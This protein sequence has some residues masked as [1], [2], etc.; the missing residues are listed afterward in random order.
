MEIKLLRNEEQY[1]ISFDNKIT[2]D[3]GARGVRDFLRNYSNPEY[4]KELKE[5]ASLC[6]DSNDIYEV[7]AY[8]GEK[9]QLC[10]YTPE[11]MQLVFSAQFFSYIT[12]EEFAEKY[13]RKRAIVQRFCKD[14]RIEGTIQVGSTWLIPEDAEYPA[15]ARVGTRVPS[16]K[17]IRSKL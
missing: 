2:Q 5:S 8:L 15:D 14:G 9:R 3:I 4:L 10:I 16:S 13:N 1:F 6:F 7:M 17:K 12:A 11:L